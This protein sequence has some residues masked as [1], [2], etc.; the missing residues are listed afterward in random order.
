MTIR[1]IHCNSRKTDYHHPRELELLLRRFLWLYLA[2]RDL[3]SRLVSVSTSIRARDRRSARR[4]VPRTRAA[5]LSPR[6]SRNIPAK[7]GKRRRRLLRRWQK[8]PPRRRIEY[9]FAML[10]DRSP[11]HWQQSILPVLIR[12]VRALSSCSRGSM[13]ASDPQSPPPPQPTHRSR[14]CCVL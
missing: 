4:R 7:P 5:A 9:H 12:P 13:L 8:S 2:N 6:T 10:S 1:E 11:H 14:R 3:A